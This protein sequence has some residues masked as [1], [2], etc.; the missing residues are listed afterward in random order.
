[1]KVEFISLGCKTNQYET[2]AMEQL[3][4]QNGYDIV[5][6][7]DEKADIYIVN[8][9]SVTNIAERK[10]R[11]MLRRAK[12][13]NPNA[14]VVAVGCYAQVANEELKNINEVDLILGINEKNNIVRI[15]E[16]YIEKQGQNENLDIDEDKFKDSKINI[17]NNKKRIEVTDVMHQNEFKDF[18]VTTYTE[19]N[20][21]VIKVQ[22]GCDRFCS[23]CIIPYARGKV[24]SRKPEVI[25]QEVTE[26]AKKG[27]KEVVLT[28]IHI[29]SYGKDFNKD[30]VKRYRDLYKIDGSYR[31]FD[32][33][34]DLA[35]GGFRLI[36]LLEIL[37]KIPN[38]ERI[39]LRFDRT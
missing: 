38:V 30:E 15:I 8:T 25:V 1:M 33:K 37:D 2:N 20:R 29:A 24:R 26:I 22:D 16:D 32:P 39:R 6:N 17:S 23:Y 5:L 12:E 11:Q 19:K 28:G 10:S 3:F 35:S 18:G 31:D 9:C 7:K 13:L 14:V 21:A 36:E 27:I 34:D 4:I